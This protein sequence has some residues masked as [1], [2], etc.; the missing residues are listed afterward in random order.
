MTASTSLTPTTERVSRALESF[1]ELPD[2]LAALMRPSRLEDSL[3]LHVP[4]IA[5]GRLEIVSC[6][7]DQL[8]AKDDQWHA[9]C[10]VTVSGDGIDGDEREVVLVGL[11]Y[12]P[13]R[14]DP[15]PLPSS[16][17]PFGADD[18]EV[19]LP[20]L[21]VRLATEEADPGLPALGDL[22]DPDAAANLIEEML[23][24]GAHPDARVRSATPDIARYKPGSRCTIVYDMTYDPGQ[25][26][27][28]DPVIAKTHQ[29]TS[30][31]A[32]LIL[33]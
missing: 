9:R 5:D 31:N 3:R 29:G 13:Q 22:T 28:P 24:G 19:S 32:Y 1:A 21:R 16:R 14:P 23:R 6:R 25:E 8:R 27:L 20:D 2:W 7:A 33:G 18:Y 12:P 26:N 30:I 17:L 15:D 4:E 11:L 10:R